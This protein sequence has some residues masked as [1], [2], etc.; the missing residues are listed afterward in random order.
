MTS[1]VP[2]PNR[3]VPPTM[4]RNPLGSVMSELRRDPLRLYLDAHH[5]YGDVVRLRLFGPVSLYLIA[6]PMDVEHVLRSH[7]TNYPKGFISAV[8][9][10]G[11]GEGLLT[12]EGELWL[13]QRR[14]IQPAFHRQRLTR[15]VMTMV[16]AANR[17]LERWE[18]FARDG[19]PFDIAAQMDPLTLGIVSR[20]LF[21]RDVSDEA[22]VVRQALNVTNAHA[23]YRYVHPFAAPAWVPT[24]RNRMA[25]AAQRTLDRVVHQVIADRRRR[26]DERDDLLAM[27][28]AARDEETGTG[29]SDKQ[30]RDEVLTILLAGHETTANAL[31]W[32]WFLLGTHPV[33]ERRVHA[34]VV[35][36]LGGR[37]PTYDDLPKLSYTRMVIDESLRLFPPAWGTA[38]QARADDEIRGY[39]IPKGAPVVIS[40]YVTHRHP[41]FWDDPA[42][43][44]PLR[45]APERSAGRHKFAYFPFSGGPRQCIGNN[46]ALIEMQIVLAM[47]VQRYRV[48]VVP[49]HPIETIAELNLRPR[50]GVRVMIREQGASHE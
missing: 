5:Q 32:T 20:T 40:Q 7:Y 31:A 14:L 37:A 2:K 22:N 19:E 23:S 21:G 39:F 41:A 3:R 28:F 34:E 43:F 12:S 15:L 48:T 11:L 33:V 16:D 8:L 42:T 49:G 18:R 24:S 13:R 45:F 25:A 1:A 46:F 36:V 44:D 10:P 4:P 38:R 47:I 26:D 9:K 27:L 29:M 30:L 6:H 17:L 50:H 35:H